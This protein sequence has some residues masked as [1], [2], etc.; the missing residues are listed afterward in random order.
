MAAATLRSRT[1]RIVNYLF[2]RDALIGLAS[3]MLLAISGYAAWHG[4]RIDYAARF[5]LEAGAYA[6]SMWWTQ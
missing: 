2:G 6:I 1:G 4:M 5:D 3:L